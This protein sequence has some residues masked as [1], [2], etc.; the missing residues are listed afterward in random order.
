MGKNRQQQQQQ[1][2]IATPPPPADFPTGDM[3]EKFEPAEPST[4]AELS[5]RSDLSSAEFEAAGGVPGNIMKDETVIEPTPQVD[6]APLT[7][8]VPNEPFE[9]PLSASASARL[10]ITEMKDYIAKMSS[11]SRMAPEVGGQVQAGL[12]HILI[13]AINTRA[14]EFD[15]VFG[16]VMK[17]IRANLNGVFS[18]TRVHR[19]TPHVTLPSTQAMSLRY[20]V[21]A[22]TA[23]AD[24]S[25]AART[26][27]KRQIN[28]EQA[29]GS[30]QIK[31]E[32]RQR[33]LAF[34]NY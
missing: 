25:P 11:P 21:N 4:G 28:I 26:L 2:S 9:L 22:L 16:L 20:L 1:Q 24:P 18:D 17:L 8:P 10:T 13:Q 32:S 5:G 34:F 12:Y 19:Y 15:V 27:A 3:P 33:V 29:L 23:L 14:E 6:I 30:R 7:P 31:E